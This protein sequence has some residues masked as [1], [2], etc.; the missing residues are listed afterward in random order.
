MNMSI[1]LKAAIWAAAYVRIL[2]DSA[3][4]FFTVCEQLA[5]PTAERIACAR[6][7]ATETVD[8]LEQS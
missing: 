6:R 2:S 4:D 5:S 3:E 7:A 8:A 1:E